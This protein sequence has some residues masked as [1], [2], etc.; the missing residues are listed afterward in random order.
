MSRFVLLFMTIIAVSLAACS[1]TS[2][3]V[4]LTDQDDGRAV[5]LRTGDRLEVT[6]S[7]NPTTGYNW[8]A[9][10]LDKPILK[11]IG[12]PE[13]KAD[14]SALGAGG[15]ITLRFEAVSA[16]QTALQLAYR[17]SWETGVSPAKT[18]RVNILVK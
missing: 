10:P 6:L 16:G 5:E 9:L 13:F 15:K 12:E 18:F 14:S 4:T 3:T 11:Q 2:T 1:T 8:V 7:G 17:R